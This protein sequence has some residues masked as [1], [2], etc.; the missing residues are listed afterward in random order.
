MIFDVPTLVAY[1]SQSMTLEPG[2]LIYTGTPEGVGPLKHGDDVRVRI[3]NLGE[4]GFH[5]VG[6]A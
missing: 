5:V 4:L 3:E 6:P 2:D 1:A